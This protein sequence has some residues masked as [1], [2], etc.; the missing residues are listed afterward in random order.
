[1][2]LTISLG[3]TGNDVKRL[4]RVLAR[5]LEWNP[6]G[7]ITGTFDAGLESAVKNVQGAHGLVVDGICGPKTWNVLP[8][9]REASPLMSLG[10]TGPAVA[11]LQLALAGKVVAVSFAPYTGFIDG[12][13]GAQT[14]TA[15]KALQ[16]WAGKVPD[17][18]IG[19]VTWFVWL[20]PGSAQQ[21]TLEG[22]SQLTNGLL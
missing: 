19:D 10:A 11:W 12:I 3:S 13:F 5:H 21:L 17:G 20:T 7:P 6:F 8:P 9:Y 1:M 4:Q 2:P 18:I 22:A 14:E 16:T 15:V